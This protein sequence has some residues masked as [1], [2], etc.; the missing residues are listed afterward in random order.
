[1]G[2]A[3]NAAQEGSQA[4][5][6]MSASWLVVGEVLMLIEAAVSCAVPWGMT[7][8]CFLPVT[9]KSCKEKERQ[10]KQTNKQKTQPCANSESKICQIRGA[11]VQLEG[12]H[13][14]VKVPCSCKDLAGIAA[15]LP[16]LP[17]PGEIHPALWDRPEKSTHTFPGVTMFCRRS[18]ESMFF[19]SSPTKC[20]AS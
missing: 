13:K 17:S 16:P 15:P 18:D 3:K 1:M 20:R 5:W 11:I 10:N 4:N 6:S 8:V 12:S 14:S 19:S 2:L 7:A 9:W